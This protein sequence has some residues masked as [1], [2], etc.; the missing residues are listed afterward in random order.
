MWNGYGCGV[1]GKGTLP[2]SNAHLSAQWCNLLF[3]RNL[4]LSGIMEPWILI[5]ILSW[6]QRHVRLHLTG[7][8]LAEC[9]LWLQKNVPAPLLLMSGCCLC[10][11][12]S[13]RFWFFFFSKYAPFL[14]FCLQINFFFRIFIRIYPFFFSV[15]KCMVSLLSALFL[16]KT[17]GGTRNQVYLKKEYKIFMSVTRLGT[18]R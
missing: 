2:L 4:C 5:G 14:G 9:F 6:W 17:G 1:R 13:I 12:G 11:V 16:H 8:V 10:G 3:M 7:C 18:T 15:I